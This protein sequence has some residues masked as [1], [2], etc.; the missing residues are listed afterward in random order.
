[1]YKEQTKFVHDQSIHVDKILPS[2]A[3]LD[4]TV[5]EARME[6]DAQEEPLIPV[7]L[8]VNEDQ[9]PERTIIYSFP[10]TVQ[11]DVHGTFKSGNKSEQ[12][13]FFEELVVELRQN[14]K[15]AEFWGAISA[16]DVHR[17][18]T[19][20]ITLNKT[21]KAEE[22]KTFEFLLFKNT[23]F[24]L[25]TREMTLK[26]QRV[27]AIVRFMNGKERLTTRAYRVQTLA[28]LC[29]SKVKH[30]NFPKILL[31][32]ATSNLKYAATK[33][34]WERNSPV[35]LVQHYSRL[36]TYEMYYK[37]EWC[38]AGN[39]PIYRFID[40]THI[41][42]NLRV[43]CTQRGIPGI[44][45]KE[46]WIEVSQKFPKLLS[47]GLIVQCL[48]KQ[49]SAHAKGVFS[50]DVEQKMVQLGY[51]AEAK[52]VKLLREFYHAVDT[53]S[54]DTPVRVQFLMN[55]FLFLKR[56]RKWNQFPPPGMYVGGIPYITFEAIMINCS[57]RIAAY[58][59]FVRNTY[60]QRAIS[61]LA[62]E[63][64]F[65]TLTHSSPLGTPSA[66]QTPKISCELVYRNTYKLDK[67]RGF[68]Y[69]TTTRN[70]YPLHLADFSAEESLHL[71]NSEG[72]SYFTRHP[73]D[74]ETENPRKKQD[75]KRN[76]ISSGFGPLVGVE[77]LRSHMYRTDEARLRRTL[78]MGITDADLKREGII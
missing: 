15:R 61:S 3:T 24:K 2:V 25:F 58:F 26:A 1:M 63:T 30:V 49:N 75:K 21:F 7:D 64:F 8:I 12:E 37:P 70:V 43:L 42:T 32:V 10:D 60:N 16:D 53:R 19:E 6:E 34:N 78:R 36:D 57:S 56:L 68:F 13:L 59:V 41:L 62:C 5:Y 69:S 17:I 44:C 47:S 67:E 20:P 9:D 39:I 11:I 35:P 55:M 74:C 76:F 48:D 28:E 29:N 18:V 52:W 40:P 23:G 22:L 33:E 14:P 45:R 46:A 27:N 71:T 66:V 4:E 65:S 31:A 72:E 54:V 38:P 73:F 50:L 77:S 51:L